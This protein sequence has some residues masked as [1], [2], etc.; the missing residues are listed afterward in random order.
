MNKNIV[1]VLIFHRGIG[2]PDL[3][4]TPQSM[5][6]FD[7]TRRQVELI[8]EYGF[9]S[10]HLLDYIAINDERYVQLFKEYSNDDLGVRNCEIG[11][12]FEMV[13][14]LVEKAGYKWNGRDGHIWEYHANHCYTIGY[15]L[16]QRKACVD[17]FMEDFKSAFGFYPKSVGSWILDAYT[18]NYMREKYGVVAACMCREQWGTDG[19]TLWGGYYGQG[20][21][22]SKNNILCPAQTKENQI[23][24]PLF[25]MLG[26]CPIYQYDMGLAVDG[27]PAEWQN[28]ATLEP[29]CRTE[30]H[31]YCGG[32]GFPNWI[33]WFFREIFRDDTLCVNYTQV[34][35]ENF[36]GWS[37][38]VA[39][40]INQLSRL[41]RMEREGRLSAQFLS[42]TAENYKNEFA[43]T[44]ANSITAETE[45]KGRD[46][47][48]FWYNCKNYRTNFYREDGKYWFRDIFVF[49]EEMLERYRDEI[50]PN[51]NMYFENLPVIDGNRQSG[52]GVRAGIYP[53]IL[54]D[55]GEY[56]ALGGTAK[57]EYDYPCEKIT[58]TDGDAVFTVSLDEEE[59]KVYCNKPYRLSLC[60]APGVEPF[61]LEN[62]RLK[63]EYI[64]FA[65]SIALKNGAFKDNIFTPSDDGT[66][67]LNMVKE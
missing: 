45:W 60:T 30:D 32:G 48:S 40:T 50:C 39:G 47:Q 23:D 19:L 53:E 27:K 42:E 7:C 6:R 52:G 1:N 65:Y 21:Y 36:F 46:K 11:M 2:S 64:G 54:G 5:D 38:Q 14:P 51:K 10:T 67:A 37:N 61:A 3:H 58:V 22:P 34:G 20:Y 44:C 43:L 8:K 33:S 28:V 17:V 18:L 56:R 49:R 26:P 9:P 29:S 25:R 57:A 15:T 62:G 24:V 12:W 35:Q 41:K 55:D 31:A 63:R 4:F 16:E 13:K 66:I 59:I